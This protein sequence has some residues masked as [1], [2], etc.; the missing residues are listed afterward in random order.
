MI[1]PAR[2]DDVDAVRPLMRGYCEFYEANPTDEGLERMAR[3]LVAT[4]DDEGI[5]LVA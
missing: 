1:R 3:A 5:L 2:E 4:P